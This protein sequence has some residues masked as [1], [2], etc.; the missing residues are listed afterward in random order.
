MPHELLEGLALCGGENGI[1]HLPH[2]SLAARARCATFCP[3]FRS[4][5]G[6]VRHFMRSDECCIARCFDGFWWRRGITYHMSGAHG[7]LLPFL[8]DFPST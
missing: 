3:H 8:R 2:V 6:I 4:G 7:L 5:F 1:K